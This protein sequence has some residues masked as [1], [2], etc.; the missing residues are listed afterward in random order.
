VADRSVSRECGFKLSDFGALL[1]E[2]RHSVVTDEVLDTPLNRL[3]RAI[4]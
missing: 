2:P 1:A 4:A 3:A